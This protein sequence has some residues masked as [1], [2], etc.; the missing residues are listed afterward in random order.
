MNDDEILK[1]EV[2]SFKELEVVS[3]VGFSNAKKK[4]D[5]QDR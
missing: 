3:K 2:S 4:S 5:E 1:K